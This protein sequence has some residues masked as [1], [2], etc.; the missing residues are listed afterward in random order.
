MEKLNALHIPFFIFLGFAFNVEFASAQEGQ[1]IQDDMSR[2]IAQVNAN[3]D[4][5]DQVTGAVYKVSSL[6]FNQGHIY[7]PL[8]LIQGRVPGLTIA[9][10]G[11]NPNAGFTMRTRGLYTLTQRSAPLIVV[12]GLPE[13]NLEGID[14]MDIASFELLKDAGAAARYGIRAAS[15]VLLVETKKGKADKMRIAYN[16]YMATES[17]TKN[18]PNLAAD[19][20]VADGG[21]SFSSETDWMEEIIRTGFSQSHQLALTGGT[22]QTSYRVALNYRSGEGILKTTDYE[23]Y[24][25]RLNLQQSFWNDRLKLNLNLAVTNRKS[26]L[27]FDEAF[28][29]GITYNPTAPIRSEDPEFETF[30]GYFQQLVF[31][32]FN[33]VALLEQNQNESQFKNYTGQLYSNFEILPGFDLNVAYHQQQQTRLNGA[34]YDRN[35][36]FR[37][38]DRNGLGEKQ[39]EDLKNDFFQTHLQ[40]EQSMGPI[41]FRLQ[42]GFNYQHIL[43]EG[44]AVSAGNFLTDAFGYHNLEAALDF[45]TGDAQISSFKSVHELQAYFGQVKMMFKDL[46]FIDAGIRR[47][48][49]SWLGAN[50]KEGVFPTFGLAMNLKQALRSE[51]LDRLMLRGSWGITGNLPKQPFLSQ[52]L[53]GPGGFVFSNG[54]FVPGYTLISEGNPDLKWERKSELN[55]GL[56]FAFWDNRLS[57]SMEYFNALS[58]DL[59]NR[60]FKDSPPALFPES[61]LNVGEIDG[62]GFELSLLAHLFRKENFSWGLGFNLSHFQQKLLGFNNQISLERRTILGAPGGSPRVILLEEGQPLGQIVGPVFTGT[63]D[64]G[65]WRFQ[66][67]NGDGAFCDCEDDHTVIGNGFPNY[68]MGLSNTIKYKNLDLNFFLR[69][70]FGHSLVN[71][72]RAKYE[73]EPHHFGIYNTVATKYLREDLNSGFIEFSDYLVEKASFLRMEN[74]TLGYNFNLKK[75]RGFSNLRIFINAMNLFTITSYT[76][77][78]P[79]LRL[80]DL[81]STSNGS[82]LFQDADPLS[83]GLDR[84]NTWLPSRA[85]VFGIN[86]GY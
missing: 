57:G 24:N 56:D 39:A 49:S 75:E 38:L 58:S 40:W 16:A 65:F 31:D 23:Q 83:P 21:F 34:Y 51:A 4:S 14:P 46:I 84:R 71:I 7:H 37:G 68:Q 11:S 80:E 32:F 60:E 1:P 59:I 81:G 29:Y 6:H 17:A 82:R 19:R 22:P 53:I 74:I 25:G 12:D 33:P 64:N 61:I 54:S 2:F 3:H 85:F 69:G 8:Q 67:I 77:A 30:D 10:P 72:M 76:G 26:Q 70:V 52:A 15:G 5:L 18:I 63:I 45:Q 43:S 66:D 44:V 55:L 86:L 28:R 62:N 36:L 48:G 47:E 50:Q 78:D 27:G 9:R 41:T 13:A 20:F 35:S 79:E 42:G 73:F